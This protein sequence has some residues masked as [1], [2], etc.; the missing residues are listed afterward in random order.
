MLQEREGHHLQWLLSFLLFLMCYYIRS[1]K[2]FT[3]PS[4]F[5]DLPASVL[6]ALKEV[7]RVQIPSVWALVFSMILLAVFPF[8]KS[9]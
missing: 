6:P 1:L 2:R 8:A 5:D 4:G 9:G 7:V 3:L